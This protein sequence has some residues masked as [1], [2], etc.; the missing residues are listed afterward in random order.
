MKKFMREMPD[1]LLTFALYDDVM[2]ACC[3]YSIVSCIQGKIE[4]NYWA[5]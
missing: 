4:N 3:K 2:D 5:I 1:P